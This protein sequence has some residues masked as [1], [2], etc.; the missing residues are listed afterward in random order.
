MSTNARVVA[1]WP[2]TQGASHSAAAFFL[3]VT[4]KSFDESAG[5][6]CFFFTPENC[7]GY[8]RLVSFYHLARK[9]PVKNLSVVA[10]IEPALS[11]LLASQCFRPRLPRGPN[12]SR[13]GAF[14][15]IFTTVVFKT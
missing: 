8:H 14:E 9:Q 4:Y 7:Q 15:I 13:I 12:S 3:L 6:C 1:R 10:G 5:E 2:R 11:G